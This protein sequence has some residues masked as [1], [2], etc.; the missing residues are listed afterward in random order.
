MSTEPGRE[1]S[2]AG[3]RFRQGADSGRE[4]SPAGTDSGREQSPAGTQNP[5]GAGSDMETEPGRA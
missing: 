1:Q 2:P 3:S 4:Q 5:A